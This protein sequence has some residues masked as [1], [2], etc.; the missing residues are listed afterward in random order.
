MQV[1]GQKS[2]VFGICHY[3]KKHSNGNDKNGQYPNLASPQKH[4]KFAKTVKIHG[5]LPKHDTK[6]R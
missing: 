6:I 4:R 1:P 5:I 2:N 3:F